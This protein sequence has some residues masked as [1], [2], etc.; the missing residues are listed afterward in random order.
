MLGGGTTEQSSPNSTNTTATNT[1]PTKIAGAVVKD[2]TNII[3]TTP[4]GR[5]LHY[6]SLSCFEDTPQFCKPA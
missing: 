4:E 6:R 5:H 1:S 2:S 3:P